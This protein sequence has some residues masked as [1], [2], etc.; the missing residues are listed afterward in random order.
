MKTE[1]NYISQYGAIR[2]TKEEAI[3]M[4]TNCVRYHNVWVHV[5]VYEEEEDK[6]GKIQKLEYLFYKDYG[7]ETYGYFLRTMAAR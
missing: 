6:G 1:R 2:M 4:I 7:N 3:E 5:T